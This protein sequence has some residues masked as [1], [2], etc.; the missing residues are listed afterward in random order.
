MD[1]KNERIA[2]ILEEAERAHASISRLTNGADP[3]WPL[4]YSW[5]LINWSELPKV[6]GAA[7]VRSELIFAL[8]TLDREY[9]GERPADPWP[10]YWAQRLASTDWSSV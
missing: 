2:T 4:F 5:W 10:A 1:E 9:R 8:M 3:E 7:P 6:V